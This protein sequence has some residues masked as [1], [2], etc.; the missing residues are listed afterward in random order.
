MLGL[1]VG[2]FALPAALLHRRAGSA[3]GAVAVALMPAHHRFRHRDRR[4]LVGRHHALH[5]HAAQFGDG[6]I[7][8]GQQLLHRRCRDTHAEHR[9][10]VA[11]SQEDRAGIGAEFQR[12]VDAKQRAWTVRRLLHDQRVAIHHIGA[13][14]AVPF[15]CHQFGIVAAQMRG[16]IQNIADKGRPPQWKRIECCHEFNLV[17]WFRSSLHLRCGSVKRTSEPK[18]H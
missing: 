1:A 10:A 16:A 12:L 17:R 13:G 18:P 14:V 5:R 2:A 15:E 6:D 9:R 3:I 4:E 7:I 11:H 8:A